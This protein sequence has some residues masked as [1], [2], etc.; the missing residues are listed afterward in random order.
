M[1]FEIP[2][3]NNEQYDGDKLYIILIR[4]VSVFHLSKHY[5]NRTNRYHEIKDIVNLVL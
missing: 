2:Y 5:L 3:L 1:E 4:K